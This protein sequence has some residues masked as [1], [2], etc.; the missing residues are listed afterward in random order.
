MGK[1]ERWMDSFRLKNLEK[2][3]SGEKQK[4]AV[5]IWEVLGPWASCHYMDHSSETAGVEDK[6]IE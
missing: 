6:G 2:Q 1:T 3:Q 5:L 4:E